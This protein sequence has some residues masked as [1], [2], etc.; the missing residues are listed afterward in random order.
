[1]YT[2]LRKKMQAHLDC[3]DRATESAKGAVSCTLRC[4]PREA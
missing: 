1:M 4:C 2:F 3:H